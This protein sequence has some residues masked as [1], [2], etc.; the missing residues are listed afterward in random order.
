MK[1]IKKFN[2]A[3]KYYDEDSAKEL[4]NNIKEN[5][6]IKLL[7]DALRGGTSIYG[8]LIDPE[9][10]VRLMVKSNFGKNYKVYFRGKNF[11]YLDISP[12]LAK[13]YFEF[14]E[15]QYERN[16]RATRSTYLNKYSKTNIKH[17]KNFENFNE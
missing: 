2:E 7:V 15:E 17:L 8:Y 13:E 5:F 1:H 9:E 16:R 11:E 4:L 6:N 3:K 14:F 12:E 10:D